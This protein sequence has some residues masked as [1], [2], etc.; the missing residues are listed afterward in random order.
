MLVE[1]ERDVREPAGDA[2]FDVMVTALPG[3]LHD[4][5]RGDGAD[6]CQCRL[7]PGV[8]TPFVT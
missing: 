5:R 6:W 4:S 3:I 8:V 1:A 2:R 7:G